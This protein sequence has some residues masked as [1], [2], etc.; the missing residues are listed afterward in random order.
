MDGFHFSLCMA[1]R[2]ELGG[3]FYKKFIL[4]IQMQFKIL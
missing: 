4:A 3:L 1:Y 2:Q